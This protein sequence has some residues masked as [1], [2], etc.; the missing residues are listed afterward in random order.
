MVEWWL[1]CEDCRLTQPQYA[2]T[3]PTSLITDPVTPGVATGVLIPKSLVWVDLENDPQRK[4]ESN[5]T[6]SLSRRMPYHYTNEGRLTGGR[7]PAQ[8]P[9]SE[10]WKCCG[11]ANTL[12]ESRTPGAGIMEA[13]DRQVTTVFTVQPSFHRRHSTKRASWSVTI[14]GERAV[15]P[16]LVVRRRW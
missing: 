15:T 14:V 11:R 16:H 3:E 1:D 6:L 12:C 2:D 13:D 8:W 10:L 5:P 4:W 9:Q 7:W